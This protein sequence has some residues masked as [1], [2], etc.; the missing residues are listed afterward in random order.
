MQ[1]GDT[2][3]WSC[4]CRIKNL[5][6]V[7]KQYMALSEQQES[8]H[9]VFALNICPNCFQRLKSIIFTG[10]TCSA[11]VH[12]WRSL[13]AR[14]QFAQA[15][16]YQITISSQ[17]DGSTDTMC[18]TYWEQG[19]GIMYSPG[20][21][22]CPFLGVYTWWRMSAKWRFYAWN[23]YVIKQRRSSTR[24]IWWSPAVELYCFH[25]SFVSRSRK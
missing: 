2:H 21:F 22:S 11:A 10:I 3:C 17:T 4:S 19:L 8:Y 1:L 5:N 18:P 12:Q 7:Q 25:C 13:G 23:W 6:S 9:T 14:A 16:K 15:G 24:I 20:V